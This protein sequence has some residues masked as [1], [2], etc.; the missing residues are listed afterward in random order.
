MKSETV[1]YQANP[2]M[3]RS[4]PARFLLVVFLCFLLV[5]IPI[6][7]AWWLTCKSTELTVTDERVSLR[8]GILSKQLNEVKLDHVRN[9]QLRQGVLQ[10]ML[11]VGWIG[12]SSA[13]QGGLEI[14]VD[15]IPAPDRVKAIIDERT[16]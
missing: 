8:K 13:G 11:G 6:L 5:G 12:I 10:R 4:S 3:F 7:I 15:G 14:E 9:V 16:R 1:L 2:A